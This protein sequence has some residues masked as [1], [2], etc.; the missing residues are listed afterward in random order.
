VWNASPVQRVAAAAGLFPELLRAALQAR[1]PADV[2][3]LSL[4]EVPEADS[5]PEALAEIDSALRT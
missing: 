1:G 4:P 5:I 3:L 2:R